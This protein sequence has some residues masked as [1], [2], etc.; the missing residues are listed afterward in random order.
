MVSL[1]EELGGEVNIYGLSGGTGLYAIEGEEMG[2]FKAY[3]A[4][5]D[6]EGHVIVNAQGIPIVSDD[7]EKVGTMNYDYQMGLGTTLS[8]PGRRLRYPQGW[9]DVLAYC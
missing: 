7:L 3:R 5:T 4:K 2:V 8:Q 9:P 1:P 6:D